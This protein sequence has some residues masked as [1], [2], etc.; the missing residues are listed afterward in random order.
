[1]E[2]YLKLMLQKLSTMMAGTNNFCPLRGSQ[3]G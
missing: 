1:V 3:K 2:T